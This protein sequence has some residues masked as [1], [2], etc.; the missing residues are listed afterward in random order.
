MKIPHGKLV[1]LAL[2]GSLGCGAEGEGSLDRNVT[3]RQGAISAGQLETGYPM[4]GAIIAHHTDDPPEGHLCT[5]TIISDSWVLT[6]QHC[7]GTGMVFKTGNSIWGGF[8]DHAVDQ[9]VKHPRIDQMLIH[10]TTPISGVPVL[11]INEG[12]APAVG[13]VC[14]GVGFGENTAPGAPD[15]NG[16]KRSATMQVQFVEPD[17]LT[18]KAVSGLSAGGDSGGPLICSGVVAGTVKGH[19]EADGDYPARQTSIY[20]TVDA[21]WIMSTIA[22]T[23]TELNLLNGWT[24]YGSRNASYA[25]VAGRVHLKGAISTTGTNAS[26]FSLPLGFRPDQNVTVAVDLYGGA[27]GSLLINKNGSVTVKSAGAFSLAASFTSL[28]GVSFV[29][30]FWSYV[31][32]TLRNNWVGGTGTSSPSAAKIGGI[33]RFRGAM[34]TTGTTMEAFTL[35]PELRPA[36]NTYLPIALNN[37]KKGRL[38]ISTSGVA[39]VV[40]ESTADAQALTSLDGAW[41]SPDATGFSNLTLQNGWATYGFGTATPAARLMNGIVHFRGALKGGTN[42][43]AFTLPAN[44]RPPV[45]VWV[46]VDVNVGH[47]GRLSISPTGTVNI[48][49]ETASDAAA[50]TS[51]EGVSFTLSDFT[52]L[53]LENGWSRAGYG[54]AQPG[55]SVTNGVVQ[56]KGALSGGVNGALFTLPV[57]AR[58]PSTIY[59]PTTMCSGW[60]GRIII[61]SNGVAT[62]YPHLGDLAK[63]QCFTGLDG[64]SFNASVLNHT[65][66]NLANNWTNYG[67]GT[68]G[69][70]FRNDNGVIRLQGAI[71]TTSTNNN[72]LIATLPAAVRPPATVYQRV[73]LVNGKKGRVTI[74][75][76]GSVYISSADVWRDAQSFTS[77]EGVTYSLSAS[78]SWSLTGQNGWTNYGTRAAAAVSSYGIVRL[79][80]SVYN[81]TNSILFTLPE[82]LRPLKTAYVATDLFGGTNGRLFISTDGSVS[83]ETAS[84]PFSNATG[85]TSLE[86]VSFSLLGN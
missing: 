30:S 20:R 22:P 5:G 63:A 55:F 50:F 71:S 64:L 7:E 56:L 67:N 14:T 79:Q 70:A 77:L 23:Y 38:F 40:P 86:G 74:A 48:Y 68:R 57:N 25:L 27:K 72:S 84:G 35:P 46:P 12:A 81:G 17:T 60:Q 26:A 4:V 51:L 69:P 73:D 18:V 83:V 43:Q 3:P 11:K 47:K 33:V 39:T 42:S 66:I 58:P 78:G 44:L 41:F 62:M 49:S 54:V 76:D 34:Q 6:A 37:G 59:L 82:A 13:T 32:L 36:N 21:P 53:V 31:N 28:E 52:P 29:P 16:I 80:G 15:G 2:V 61:N 75:T 45:N 65:L 19:I 9:Q 1:A 24:Q 85:F 8:V 10:L